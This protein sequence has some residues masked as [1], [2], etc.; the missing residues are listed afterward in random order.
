MTYV[1]TLIIEENSFVITVHEPTF[2]CSREWELLSNFKES[3]GTV[4]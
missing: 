2:C 3:H 4:S 1:V